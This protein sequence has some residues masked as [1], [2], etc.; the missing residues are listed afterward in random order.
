MAGS[1]SYVADNLVTDTS[2]GLTTGAGNS[3][4]EGNVL[5]GNVEG[6]QANQ[7][8]PTNEVTGTTSS[9]TT[10]TPTPDSGRSGS[11]ARTARGT[12]GTGDRHAGCRRRGGDGRLHPR[13][14]TLPTDPVD[15]RLHRVDGTPTL[16]RAPAT[17][18]LS[19]L[20]GTV[21]GMRSES[22]VDPA[23]LCEPANPELLER[24]EWESP[25]R[26]C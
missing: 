7:I 26:A 1:R 5:A 23:P 8:L 16:A 25:E 9:E 19:A 22:I 14:F 11:G 10:S 6:V 13:A 20:E 15:E 21:S 24:T 18:A 17:D 2:V 12:S 3:I 4:Y